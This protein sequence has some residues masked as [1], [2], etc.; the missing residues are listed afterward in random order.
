MR[1][2][3]ML[4]RRLR[5]GA[6]VMLGLAMLG[7]A[8]PQV[9]FGQKKTKKGDQ[10]DNSIPMPPMPAPDELEN[11]MGEMLGA[12]QVGD[13]DAMHKYYADDATFTS[14]AYEPPIIGWQSYAT[15]YQK[16][17]TRIQGMQF[18]RRNTVIRF[19]NDTAWATYQWEMFATVDNKPMNA[20]GHT[21]LVFAKTGDHWLI[22]HNHTSQVCDAVSPAPATSPQ[23]Q[24]E[25]QPKN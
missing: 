12:W 9:S 13:V 3:M 10:T 7:L 23:V 1:L 20:Y 14:G 4:R 2:M 19:R 22:V 6:L 24:P 21:T 17:R 16:Q 15:A 25:Q 11:V 5:G 18:V 8:A